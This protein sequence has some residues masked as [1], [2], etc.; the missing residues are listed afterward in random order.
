MEEGREREEVGATSGG[1]S[2]RWPGLSK[3][4]LTAFFLVPFSSSSP[5]PSSSSSVF[6]VAVFFS[7]FGFGSAFALVALPLV[8]A[9]LVVLA[10]RWA[11]GV[12]SS[13]SVSS[14]GAGA[15]AAA[16]Q[17]SE[18]GH[19]STPGQ[20]ERVLSGRPERVLTRCR[21]RSSQHGCLHEHGR[22]PRHRHPT[23]T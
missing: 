16:T 11:S 23:K 20:P 14:L 10:L 5:G 22:K 18:G 19:Q 4:F 8:D 21:V 6:F 1:V 3:V 2:L 17:T 13:E 9:D 7:F 12:S 15:E